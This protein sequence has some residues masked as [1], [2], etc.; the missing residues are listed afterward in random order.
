MITAEE[1]RELAR[2]AREEPWGKHLAHIC[3][4]L[5][6]A[7]REGRTAYETM[8]APKPADGMLQRLREQGFHV[9][10]ERDGIWWAVTIRWGD[11]I[12][13]ADD[14]TQQPEGSGT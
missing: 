6:Q 12:L 7:A 8:I 10:L 5:T 14:A 3:A 9:D 1:A 4:D 13:R 2:V 11:D